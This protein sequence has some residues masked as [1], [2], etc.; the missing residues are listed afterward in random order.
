[1]N[2]LSNSNLL[3]L[4][5]AR[6]PLQFLCTEYEIPIPINFV[7]SFTP[8]SLMQAHKS[9]SESEILLTAWDSITLFI[10]QHFQQVI[11]VYWGKPSLI[12]TFTKLHKLRPQKYCS[13][14]DCVQKPFTLRA[15]ASQSSSSGLTS[16]A[17][18]TRNDVISVS[19]KRTIRYVT[20]RGRTVGCSFCIL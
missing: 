14:C 19:A 6:F 16:L 5:L 10:L 8:G 15:R 17:T 13:Y 3:F 12:K 20:G 1:M 9:C 18:P 11:L 7:V 4:S 2:R